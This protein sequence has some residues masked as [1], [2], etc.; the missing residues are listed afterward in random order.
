MKKLIGVFVA[1]LLLTSC[2]DSKKFV[3][4]GKEVTVEP[5][6][7]ANQ[8]A[9]KVEGVVYQMNAGNV[10]WDIILFETIIVPIYLTGW[11]LYEPIAYIPENK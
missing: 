5:Y 10:F 7:W 4:E 2:A 11:Q 1:L 3:I 6:G 9:K 8:D